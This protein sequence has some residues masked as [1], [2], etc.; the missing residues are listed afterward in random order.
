MTDYLIQQILPREPTPAISS[1]SEDSGHEDEDE[2]SS[3]QDEEDCDEF[4]GAAHDLDPKLLEVLFQ[5]IAVL[6][7]MYFS[8]LS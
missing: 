8:M 5:V 1:E 7:R 6:C 3:T 2:Q 4:A